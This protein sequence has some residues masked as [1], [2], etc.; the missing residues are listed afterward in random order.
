MARTWVLLVN[1]K[2]QAV[3]RSFSVNTTHRD[4]MADLKNK[5]KKERRNALQAALATLMP[6]ISPC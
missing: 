3:G 2:F 5:V 4:L 1:Q 6:R